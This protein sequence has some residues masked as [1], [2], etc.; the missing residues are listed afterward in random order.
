M[1]YGP[2]RKTDCPE[3]FAA[4][5]KK[6]HK[7]FFYR[8]EAFAAA[9]LCMPRYS[10]GEASVGTEP[11]TS[12]I[13]YNC[14]DEQFLTKNFKKNAKKFVCTDGGWK[15]SPRGSKVVTGSAGSL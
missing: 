13:I 6:I 7:F 1:F 14:S 3:S 15:I 10:L 9:Y 4:T 5:Y 8:P 11:Y 2:G 12:S